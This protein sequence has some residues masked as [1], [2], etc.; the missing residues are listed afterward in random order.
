[1]IAVLAVSRTWNATLFAPAPPKA[2]AGRKSAGSTGRPS[3]LTD[4][5][6]KEARRRRAEGATFAELARS[7]GVGN[8]TFYDCDDKAPP[9]EGMFWLILTPRDT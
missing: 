3:I 5:Q 8:S 2:A 9:T 4:A 7:Y 1:M 6:K